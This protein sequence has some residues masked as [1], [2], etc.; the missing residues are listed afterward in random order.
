M[1]P[2][3]EKAGCFSRKL[4][5]RSVQRSEKQSERP[6]KQ[7][8]VLERECVATSIITDGHAEMKL[9]RIMQGTGLQSNTLNCSIDS[10]IYPKEGISAFQFRVSRLDLNRRASKHPQLFRKT[11][12]SYLFL[13]SLTNLQSLENLSALRYFKKDKFVNHLVM[14]QFNISS[15]INP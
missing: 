7:P 1:I 6:W 11:Q 3:W 8:K 10:D 2:L 5:M 13:K 12:Q 14:L 4:W 9:F 15:G